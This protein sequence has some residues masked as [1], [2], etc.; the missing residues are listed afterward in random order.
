MNDD[1]N[2]T[3]MAILRRE[4]VPALGCTEPVAVALASALAVR[5][6]GVKP[7]WIDVLVSGNL[8]KNG[9]GVMVP[10]TGRAG[11]GIAAAAG[12]LAG[13]PD[14]GLEVL[15]N[16][17]PDV[18]REAG[19]MVDS[20][21]I[22]VRLADTPKVLYAE[23]KA[24]A[25]GSWAR[26]VLED[27]HTHVTLRERDGQVLFREEGGAAAPE[28]VAEADWPLTLARIWD[29][30]DNP[31]PEALSFIMETATLNAAAAE[32]GLKGDY[33]LKV[34]K[35]LIPHA[36]DILG[37]DAASYAVRLS[38]AGSDLRMAG[39]MMPVM[40]NSGSG[41][42]G[43]ACT[44]PVLAIA[45]R[46]GADDASLARALLVSHLVS[47]HIKHYVGKLSA[48]CGAITA[49][50][51]A[52]CGLVRLLGGDQ[53]A[54]GRAIRN[55][56][57]DLAG[58]IC[59]GAKSTCALKVATAAWAAIKAA[60]LALN[61]QAPDSDNGIVDDDA[62]ES[63]RHLAKLATEGMAQTDEVILGIMMEKKA[64]QK[65]DA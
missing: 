46:I 33:G 40:S 15:R 14:L 4:V 54:M 31:P 39:A 11:L 32:E 18:A 21:R 8:Y 50:T 25:G 42:Q 10:G 59:D 26:T 35:S 36:N 6:L 16:V 37:D 24:S 28:H 45:R 19:A 12:A 64:K 17:T 7:E 1:F 43:I 30:A 23:A 22:S 58:M 52:A 65:S 53:A 41:N 2:A 49:S 48:L 27:A 63:I 5:D 47:I 55:M 44:I 61:N 29:F 57:G 56:A 20:G 51:G 62:E 38:A 13:D 9:L 34:G 3:C 60:R